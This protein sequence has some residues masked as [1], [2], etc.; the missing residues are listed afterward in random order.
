MAF[1]MTISL[2]GMGLAV[3]QVQYGAGQHRGDVLEDRYVTGLKLNFIS[4]PTY[5]FAICFVKLSV[6]CSL[7]R[8]ASTKTYRYLIIG[9]MAF[10]LFY[11]TGCFFVRSCASFLDIPLMSLRRLSS[12]VPIFASC[13]IRFISSPFVGLKKHYRPCHIPTSP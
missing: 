2:S 7:L 10:M 4:Q 13:G 1:A 5:L 12:N 11:T 6:G 9:I 8:I 3:A